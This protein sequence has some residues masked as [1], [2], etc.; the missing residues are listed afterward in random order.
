MASKKKRNSFES[1]VQQR[2]NAHGAELDVDG[3]V[4]K[5]TRAAI[6]AFQKLHGLRQTGTVNSETEA[7]LRGDPIK[8]ARLTG[9]MDS[10]RSRPPV[11][12]GQL[13]LRAPPKPERLTGEVGVPRSPPPSVLGTLE[14]RSGPGG[15]PA[16]RPPPTTVWNEMLEGLGIQDLVAPGYTE[17]RSRPQVDPRT[18]NSPLAGVEEYTP[19]DDA[20]AIERTEPP[21]IYSPEGA[22]KPRPRTFRDWR[23]PKPG[24]GFTPQE[25]IEMYGVRQ[26]PSL[27]EFDRRFRGE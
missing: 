5:K 1:W 19:P 20:A 12:E 14:D 10:P 27:E 7:I 24:R 6:I 22:P 8:P 2:L 4:G 18:G 11:V 13:V 25:I 15:S 17:E 16:P 3:R 9:K 21:R 23:P 26:P